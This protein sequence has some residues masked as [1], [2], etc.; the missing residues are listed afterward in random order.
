MTEENTK[1]IFDKITNHSYMLNFQ[2][3]K[4]LLYELV[5]KDIKL[6]YRRSFLGAFWLFLSPLLYTLVL[7]VV[8]ST[9]F[10]RSIENY[11]VYLLC[12]RLVFDFFSEGTKRG[13]NSLIKASIIKRVYV[14][15][16]VYPL[17]SVIGSFVTFLI[18]LFVLLVMAIVTGVV[19][20]YHLLYLIVPFLLVFFMVLGIALT[21]ASVVIFFRDFK[22]L[23]GVFLSLLMWSSAI[24]YP[25]EIIPAKFRFIINFNPV[26]QVIDMV[27]NSVL[28]ATP[29]NSFQVFYVLGFTVFFLILGIILLY[30]YQDK[31]ILY[32]D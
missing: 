19:F 9:F 22:H 31:F 16:Y 30:K 8:F 17:G 32:M 11:P 5:K 23:W 10:H 14:P 24:F 29:P 20:T 6:K 4:Y 28:Y 15:K 1:G 13:M 12:G 7:T 3:Y 2:R 27:R 18:T 21:L 25:V 26:F